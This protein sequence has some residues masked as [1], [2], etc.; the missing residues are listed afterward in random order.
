MKKVYVAS[1]LRNHI[2]VKDVI[3]KFSEA[4]I[5]VSYDWTAHGQV[6][7]TN[8]LR[9]YGYGELNGILDS[10]IFFF[11]QPAR[12]GSHIELGI[13]IASVSL[14]YDKTIIIVD[15]DHQEVEEK[16]FYHLDCIRRFNNVDE[17]FNFAITN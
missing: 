12:T 13:A 3:N 8:K 11:I 4:G 5:S 6:F 14:G 7:D 9:E 17:A 16:T 15:N 10:D 1:S 2:M